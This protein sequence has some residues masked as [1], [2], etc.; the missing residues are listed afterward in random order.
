[1]QITEQALI[2]GVFSL[3]VIGISATMSIDNFY[4][5]QAAVQKAKAGLEECPLDP[6][7]MNRQTIWIKDCEA[8]IKTIKKVQDE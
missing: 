6:G 8:Y 3:M 2:A 1:M 4:E 7:S 5:E